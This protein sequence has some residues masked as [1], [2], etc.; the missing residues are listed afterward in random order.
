MVHRPLLPLIACNPTNPLLRDIPGLL[1]PVSVDGQTFNGVFIAGRS[2]E[3]DPRLRDFFGRALDSSGAVS[4]DG[5]PLREILP[6]EPVP[7]FWTT[8]V[9]SFPTTRREMA[10][11]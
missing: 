4:D 6:E 2:G 3:E 10:L 11:A 5:I 9:V 1:N 7:V 8:S